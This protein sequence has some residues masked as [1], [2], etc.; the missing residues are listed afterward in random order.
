MARIVGRCERGTDPHER[1]AFPVET[2]ESPRQWTAAPS[3]ATF[4]I[5]PRRGVHKRTPFDITKPPSEALLGGGLSRLGQNW[6][7]CN[8]PGQA[9]YS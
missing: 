4:V 1:G 7:P 5:T 8:G 9:F 3:S 6:R 2:V